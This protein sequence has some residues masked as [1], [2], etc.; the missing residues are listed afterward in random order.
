MQ[1]TLI[2][3]PS[4]RSRHGVLVIEAI[5]GAII[6][7]AA[8]AMLVPAMTAVRRQR[9]A[10]R[11]ETLAMLELNNVEALLPETVDPASLP[12]LTTWFQERYRHAVLETELMPISQDA[13]A[14]QPLRLTIRQ[15]LMESMPEQKVSIVI[16]RKAGEATP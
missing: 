12:K 11:F 9:M 15:P 6:L 8:I 14:L 1:K 5:I 2:T 3:F 4:Q 7:G 13:K 10:Q 16:W